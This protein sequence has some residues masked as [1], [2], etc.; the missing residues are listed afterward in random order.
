M[1][2]R[3]LIAPALLLPLAACDASS[4]QPDNELT[5]EELVAA[6]PTSDLLLIQYPG[7]S[8]STKTAVTK[9]AVTKTAVTTTAV[10]KTAVTT[11]GAAKTSAEMTSTTNASVEATCDAS[12]NSETAGFYQQ[13]CSVVQYVNGVV[14]D[15]LALLSDVTSHTPTWSDTEENTAYWGPYTQDNGVTMWFAMQRNDDGTYSYQL[16]GKPMDASDADYLPVLSGKVEAGVSLTYNEG[17]FE[18]DYD[19]LQVLDPSRNVAGISTYQYDRL[20]SQTGVQAKFDGLLRADGSLH[21]GAVDYVLNEDSSGELFYTFTDDIYV[22]EDQ[23]EGTTA[24]ETLKVHTR[25]LSTGS[26][27][28]D[29]TL[30]AGDLGSNTAYLT[31]CWDVSYHA[32]YGALYIEDLQA[33]QNGDAGQCVFEQPEFP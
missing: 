31:E 19:H 20:D 1:R 32:V 15:V 33:S 21:D 24:Q 22:P 3:S 2:L 30:S 16:V 5:T 29:A 14:N 26:G 23:E 7:S 28:S 27:R 4:G 12:D 13:G 8:S 18:I 10:T 9:T 6:L 25:W 11:Y 17:L